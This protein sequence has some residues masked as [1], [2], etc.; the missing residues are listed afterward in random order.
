MFWILI[1]CAVSG[2]AADS[3]IGFYL[4]LRRKSFRYVTAVLYALLTGIYLAF[5]RSP[6]RLPALTAGTAGLLL[7]ASPLYIEKI[8]CRTYNLLIQTV[9]TITILYFTE[10][11]MALIA[12]RNTWIACFC[13]ILFCN[14]LW[15]GI[16]YLLRRHIFTL[17]PMNEVFYKKSLLSISISYAI[18]LLGIHGRGIPRSWAEIV[19]SDLNFMTTVVVML[20]IIITLNGLRVSES[21]MIKEQQLYSIRLQNRMLKRQ[22]DDTM[23]HNRQLR[24]IRHD[25]R[26]HLSVIQGLLQQGELRHASAFISQL[27]DQYAEPVKKVYCDNPLI[28]AILMDTGEACRQICA[29]FQPVIRLDAEILADETD[30]AALLMNI[31]NNAVDCIRGLS[32]QNRPFIRLCLYT[33]HEFLVIKCENTI[34]YIPEIINNR[35]YSSKED[36]QTQHGIGLESI[37]YIC[38]KYDGQAQLQAE[39]NLFTITAVIQNRPSAH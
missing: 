3:Q 1:S 21:A 18:L 25:Y 10:N 19:R 9:V 16:M 20:A 22:A 23:I 32:G 7:A 29:D 2:I 36:S 4:N 8:Y 15:T 37:H 31:L 13:T 30:L 34:S 39:E 35:I 24:R 14:A 27:L 11:L 33:A 17:M 6:A 38:D 28:N 26:H 12:P 5:C